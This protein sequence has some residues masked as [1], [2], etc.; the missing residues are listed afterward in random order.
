MQYTESGDCQSRRGVSKI[1]PGEAPL[2]IN[3]QKAV[4]EMRYPLPGFLEEFKGRLLKLVKSLLR[5]NDSGSLSF[6][7]LENQDHDIKYESPKLDK[8]VPLPVIRVKVGNGCGKLGVL[9]GREHLC[10]ACNAPLSRRFEWQYCRTPKCH[11][12]GLRQN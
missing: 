10:P 8:G 7:S 6:G 2:Q 12:Q 1:A 5:E 3:L 11:L 4:C 9:V